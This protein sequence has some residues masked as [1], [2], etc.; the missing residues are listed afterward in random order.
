MKNIPVGPDLKKFPVNSAIKFE[1]FYGLEEMQIVGMAQTILLT[2][3][4]T[5]GDSLLKLRLNKSL[6]T[7]SAG[8]CVL[9]R[10]R[11]RELV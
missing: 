3:T 4:S 11:E 1:K 9:V 8:T 6:E 2:I 10:V 7:I 5:Y